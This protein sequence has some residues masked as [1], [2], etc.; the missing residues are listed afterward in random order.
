MWFNDNLP[1]TKT[2]PC[3]LERCPPTNCVPGEWSGS[4][5]CTPSGTA[6]CEPTATSQS[7]TQTQTRTVAPAINGGTCSTADSATTRTGP[8]SLPRCP[9]NCAP[10]AWTNSGSCTPSGTATC[11]PTA[12]SQSG[13]QTRTR[14]VEPAQFGGTCSSANSATSQTTPCSLSRCPIDCAVGTWTNSGSCTARPGGSNCEVSATSI[15]GNQLQTRTFA[16]A[17]FGGACPNSNTTQTIDCTLSNR[18]PINCVVGSWTNSGTCTSRPGG[19]NCEV[20]ATS[21]S[22]TQLQTR[23]VTPAQFGGSCPNSNTTQSLDC[24]LPNRC[25]INCVPGAWSNSGTCVPTGSATCESSTTSKSGTQMQ[26][27]TI[28]PA[29]F[30]GS[31]STADSATSQSIPCSLPLCPTNCRPG[32]WTNS[33][34]CTAVPGGSNCEI[35]ATSLSGRQLQSRIIEPPTNGGTCSAEDSLTSQTINCALSTRCPIN[36]V[37]GSWSNSGTCMPFGG[38]TCESSPTSKS[39]KQTQ[40]R[41][42]VPSQFGGTCADPDTSKT[43]DC[44]LSTRCPIPCGLSAWTN[45]GTCSNTLNLACEPNSSSQSG[46]QTQ[47]QT[48]TSPAQF[49]GACSISGT[50]SNTQRVPCRLSNLPSCINPFGNETINNLV[51]PDHKDFPTFGTFPY[52]GVLFTADNVGPNIASI[53]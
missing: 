32:A 43:L 21:L 33:G 18:C 30:N 53:L 45:V 24:A 29:Q 47:F 49:G 16:P 50:A 36:C 44:A 4:G 41:E 17:Q 2:V 31:C 23:T 3:S 8:C 34:S 46:L 22:G 13:T 40:L 10:G 35:S 20:S 28:T 19:S 42:V 7:G 27:R 11:E 51:I 39:G 15:S 14:N 26:T 48:I 5:T 52:N 38:V 37:P 25:P 1:L 6:T 12:T 9:V